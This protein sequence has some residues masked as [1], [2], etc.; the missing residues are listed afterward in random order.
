MTYNIDTSGH[1][2]LVTGAARG[3]GLAIARELAAAGSAVALADLDA[4]L[5]DTC[6]HSIADEFGAEAIG[7]GMDVSDSGS[8]DSGLAEVRSRLGPPD[9]LVNN[10]G[11]YRS[12]P[13]NDIDMQTW[14]LMLDVMLT[15]PLLLCR[16]TVPHMISERWGRIIN[17]GSQVSAVSF[18]EDVAYSAAKAGI[19][20][21][22]RS[23]AAE[24]AKHQ[25]SVN[26]ICPGNI[27]TDL[28]RETGAAIEKRDGLEPGQFLRE[29]DSTIPLG[30]LGDPA[31]VA[32][33]VVFLASDRGGY[34]T[35]QSIHVNGG[36]YQ[37]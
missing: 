7:I 2:A 11:L 5:A 3:I 25:I 19:A 14:R 34:I 8:I 32:N 4:E 22:S 13:L 6:A 31:D 17:M 26:A 20:G 10:A 33:L 23:M 36:L 28:M 21:V 27:L 1:T 12:T 9:I 15:G 24:L 29:R 18:G 16:A 37:T 30:R 35:G